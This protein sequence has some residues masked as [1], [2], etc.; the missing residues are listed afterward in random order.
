M[1][2]IFLSTLVTSYTKLA[3]CEVYCKELSDWILH[4]L[5][6]LLE[7]FDSFRR[8]SADVEIHLD[9]K[10]PGKDELKGKLT[11]PQAQNGS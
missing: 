2:N 5:P 11:K 4:V 10:R 7:L 3:S 9:E 1:P 8:C 6:G